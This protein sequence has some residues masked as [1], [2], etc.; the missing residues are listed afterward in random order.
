[1]PSD[2]ARP[3]PGYAADFADDYDRWFGKPGITGATVDALAALAGHGPVLEL[4]VG[5][6]RVALPLRARGLAVH[7]VDGSEAMVR[8]L[9]A[10]PGGDEIPVTVGDFAEVPVDGSFSLVYLAGGTFAE[11]PDQAAQ[12]RCFGNAAARLAPG[13]LFV[14]DAHVPEALAAAG[15]EIVAEGEDLLVLC[16]RRLD[17]AAQR[18]HSH[19]VVHEGGATRHLRVAFRYAGHGEL[20]LMA[21]QAGLRLKERWG[22][23]TGAPFTGDS[24]YHVSVY[25]RP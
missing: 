12:V 2:T 8:R 6:G 20:D 23:W 19:Y 15:P 16:H 24:A 13:G 14:L 4:G 5:T 17:T 21:A 18:Y 9:R 25:E 7:G 3:S 22:G 11:L 1:M 10:K